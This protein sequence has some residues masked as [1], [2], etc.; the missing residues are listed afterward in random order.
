MDRSSGSLKISIFPIILLFTSIL[1][2][3]IAGLALRRTEASGYEVDKSG[4]RSPVASRVVPDIEGSPV[5]DGEFVHN[6]GK[7]HMNITNWG[8]LGSMPQSGYPMRDAPSAQYPAGSGVE[9]LFAAGIW[10]GAIKN[11]IPSVSTGYPED[12]FRPKSVPSSTIYRSYESSRG[13]T[14]LPADADD[15]GDGAMDEDFLNGIDDDGDGKIDEDYAAVGSQMFSCEYYDNEPQSRLIWPEHTPL[16]I[17]I[18]QQTFQWGETTNN[19][20]VGLS[21]NITNISEDYLY[22]MYIGIYA[23]VDA[24]PRERGS[25]QMDDQVGY[26]EGFWCA[27]W[28]A[29]Q[30]PEELKISYVYDDDGDDGMTPGYFGI[31]LLGYQTTVN[32]DFAPKYPSYELVS[33][34][35]FRGLRPFADGGDATNDFERYEVM[36]TPAIDQNTEY[37]GDYRIMVSTGPFPHLDPGESTWLD[38]AFVAGDGLEEMLDHAA[39]ARKI[40]NGIWFDLDNNPNTGIMGRESL[41]QGPFRAYDPDLCDGITQEIRLTDRDFIWAN[42]DCFSE[43]ETFGFRDCYKPMYASLSDY[44]TGVEGREHQLR[45]VTNCAPPSPNMRVTAGD[46]RVTVFWD[47][48]SEITPD[49]ITQELDFEGYM[50]WRADDWHRPLGTSEDNGPSHDLWTLLDTRDLVNGVPPDNDLHQPPESGGWEYIPLK[51]MED[52][53][54]YLDAFM[55]VLKENPA[56]TVPCPYGLT[57]QECDTIE[58]LARGYL[59]FSRMKRYYC[60]VDYTAKNGLPYFYSVTAFDH[61]FLNGIP[62]EPAR[63]NFPAAN[64]K[65]VVPISEAQ[66][67]EGFDE[68]DIY[69]VPNPVTNENM[70]PWRLGPTNY[71]PSG[72]KLE[73]RNLP[74]CKSTI[75]I[76]TVSGDLV[77]VIEHDGR[78]GNGTAPW[79][80]VSRNG[81]DIVSGVY[82]FAVDPHDGSFPEVVGKFVVIR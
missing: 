34:K 15:D 31:L 57:R 82:I 53:N 69:V 41:V 30:F 9:Y 59:G 37:P 44:M 20:F 7:L 32:G 51:Y 79:N 16:D 5:V 76:F 55:D 11:G 40:Y 10:V 78:E 47:D 62:S 35:H 81:Q 52:F 25:Y 46:G 71:D 22:D 24:G 63:Y 65:Y 42:L 21:Y 61:D 29:A 36:S 80:L 58:V 60:Y 14:R 48:E 12:E 66:E 8:I 74:A 19:D 18:R 2:I 28:G 4:G 3:Y 39:I 68:E 49:F 33:F 43:R 17:R 64:F 75:R 13:G 27:P 73:F 54:T 70:E 38:V 23:D 72:M 77:K 56:D 6:V 50:I 26:W 45:W 67:A 1:A